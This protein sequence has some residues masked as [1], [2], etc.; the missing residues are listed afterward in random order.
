MVRIALLLIVHSRR[1]VLFEIQVSV[2]A[3]FT[4]IA[5]DYQRTLQIDLWPL[6]GRQVEI[7]T[8]DDWA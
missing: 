8:V 3:G 5:G 4:D 6:P 2:T 1:R 7:T